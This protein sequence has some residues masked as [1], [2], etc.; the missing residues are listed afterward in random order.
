MTTAGI[1]LAAGEGSRF[2]GGTHKLLAPLRGRPVLVWVVEAA[3]AAGLDEV[4]VVTG[5]VEVGP[6]LVEFGLADRVEV[7]VNRRWAEGQATSLGAGL[8]AAERAGHDVAV[9]G[10]GDQPLVPAA[11][12]RLV[13]GADAELPIVVATYGGERRNPV[14][15]SRSVWAELPTEGDAG[16]RVLMAGRPELVSE[17]ACP[18]EPADVDTQED[19]ARWS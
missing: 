11:A 19:L 3:L 1:V 5:A 16:A 12:W 9:I 6:I 13:A 17:V 7:V 4:L 8:A 18:G 14:R 2:T 15:L 10:L